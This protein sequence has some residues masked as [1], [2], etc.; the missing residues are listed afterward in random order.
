MKFQFRHHVIDTDLSGR[1]Y[2]QTALADLDG[3]GRLEYIMGRSG[4]EIYWPGSG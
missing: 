3:D 2:A 1:S 4:G